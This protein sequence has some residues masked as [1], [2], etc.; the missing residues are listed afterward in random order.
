MVHLVLG[1]TTSRR[2]A[3]AV[4]SLWQLR[5]PLS[6]ARILRDGARQTHILLRR[7]SSSNA[8]RLPHWAASMTGVCSAGLGETKRDRER[9]ASHHSNAVHA[10]KERSQRLDLVHILTVLKTRNARQTVYGDASHS[11]PESPCLGFVVNLEV[12]RRS[13]SPHGSSGVRTHA[14]AAPR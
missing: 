5:K 10:P 11:V 14:S 8:T 13:E 7:L 2:H 3:S 6:S 1:W 12:C 9:R 4:P